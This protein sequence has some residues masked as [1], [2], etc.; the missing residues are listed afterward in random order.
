MTCSSPQVEARTVPLPAGLD[1]LSA[2]KEWHE[3]L[4]MTGKFGQVLVRLKVEAR[5]RG[6][7]LYIV[8][9]TWPPAELFICYKYISVCSIRK[10]DTARPLV[11]TLLDYD[12]FVSKSS[13]RL[14][15]RVR[16]GAGRLNFGRECTGVQSRQA[17]V[18]GN[19]YMYR[20]RVSGFDTIGQ[21]C[22]V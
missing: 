1:D 9:M 13:G 16:D 14:V 5:R 6:D 2:L 8:K 7:P 10:A 19:I 18:Q 22:T 21:M 20:S 3:S 15:R 11:H 12:Y 17:Q 4:K